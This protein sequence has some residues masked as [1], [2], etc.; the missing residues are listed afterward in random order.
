MKNVEEETLYRVDGLFHNSELGSL[1]KK[2]K[3]AEHVYEN[4]TI[5]IHLLV[6]HWVKLTRILDHSL[7]NILTVPNKHI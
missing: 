7:N 5:F 4:Y 6:S 1:K 2:L 3:L